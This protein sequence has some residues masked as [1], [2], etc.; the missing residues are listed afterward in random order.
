MFELAIVVGLLLLILLTGLPVA[1]GLGATAVL[2]ALMNDISLSFVGIT[3]LES[4]HSSTLMAVPL[5][6]L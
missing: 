4:L 6:F 5:F 1:F 2:L 3:V